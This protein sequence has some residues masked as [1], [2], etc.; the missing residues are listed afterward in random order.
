MKPHMNYG[1]I[2][3][4]ILRARGENQTEVARRLGVTQ[5]TISRWLGGKQEPEY[6]QIEKILAEAR[7][8]G[9]INGTRALDADTVPVVG[10]VGAGGSIV[11]GEGQ[12]P[13]EEAEMPPGGTSKDT[14]AVVVRGDSMAPQLEDGWLVYYGAET[15]Q[16]TDDLYN[17][18]CVVRLSDGRV[19]I[20]KLLRGRGPG[21]YDLYSVNAS[22]LLDQRVE[23]AARVTWISP[24]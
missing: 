1:Q 8:L 17:R 6:D 9:V 14:V 18:L 3:R 5:P 24:K 2:I 21:L 22:P 16:P 23:W 20:K 4:A 19:L 12:G 10:Y 11:F 15:L 7:F 13:F